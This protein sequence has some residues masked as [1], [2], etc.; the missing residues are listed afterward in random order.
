MC[1]SS[2]TLAPYE[3][4]P[5]DYAVSML[6]RRTPSGELAFNRCPPNATGKNSN[7][8]FSFRNRQTTTVGHLTWHWSTRWK[9]R[10]AS[11][12]E[13]Q[14][15]D[16]H[17]FFCRVYFNGVEIIHKFQSPQWQMF[18]TSVF[19]CT[20]TAFK[21]FMLRVPRDF[22]HLHTI[23]PS[24]ILSTSLWDCFA[25]FSNIE[26]K[27]KKVCMFFQQDIV[28][29]WPHGFTPFECSVLLVSQ[30]IDLRKILV[31]KQIS[32]KGHFTQM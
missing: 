18:Q 14:K 15:K 24:S 6:W 29:L 32:L 20:A 27:E 17:I 22:C 4:C 31:H 10:P 23:K 7:D 12:T 2:F 8:R 3:I 28:T 26:G 5:E 30:Q 13:K 19:S 21:C 25:F 11:L 9:N 1:L 16:W